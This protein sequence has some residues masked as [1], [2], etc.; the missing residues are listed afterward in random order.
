MRGNATAP[1]LAAGESSMR[2]FAI[3][4]LILIAASVIWYKWSFPTVSYRYR[5]SIAVESDGQVHFGSGVIE[6]WHRFNPQW[7]RALVGGNPADAGVRGQG[8][9]VDLG[10]RGTLVAAL[11]TEPYDNCSVGAVDLV[12]RAYEPPSA[13]RRCIT[14]YR[15]S[16]ENERELAQKE[17]S[18]SLTA[19][20]LPAFFWFSEPPN[21]AT[22]RPVTPQNFA[23]VIG[24][25][26]RL[27]SAQVEITHDPIVIDIDK[28]LPACAPPYWPL[29]NGHGS[30]PNTLIFR[31]GLFISWGDG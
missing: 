29:K 22:A 5:L 10:A 2:K 4:A 24:D 28:K 18:L 11:Y 20:D 6:V 31:C 8:I 23:S 12:G 9:F 16:L 26:V 7:A 21:L 27:V 19:D 3:I 30:A 1:Q 17:S 25:S 14:G 15:L 13:R